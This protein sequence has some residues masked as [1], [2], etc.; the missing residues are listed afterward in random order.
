MPPRW[1]LEATI[2]A[3]T[4]AQARLAGSG[5]QTSAEALEAARL[6][7]V[8]ASGMLDARRKYDAAH[9]THRAIL[10]N[11][12]W[13]SILGPEGVRRTILLR[14]LKPFNDRLSEMCRTASLGTIRVRGDRT[15]EMETARGVLPYPLL[16][17]AESKICD[18]CI[19]V[20]I[21]EN[22]ASE[23]IIIDNYDTLVGE[24]RTALLKLLVNVN[25]PSILGCAFSNEDL[26]PR[27]PE[28]VGRT[29][30]IEEGRAFYKP[31]GGA[32]CNGVFISA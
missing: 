16:S 18:I 10:A 5:D 8:E 29:F 15:V 25:I 26:P 17:G 14:R 21:A 11:E 6:A 24:H 7:H 9:G 31:E 19:Q 28:N 2:K 12:K 20:A 4:A 22:D 3:A 32:K 1:R 23:L 30:W 13:Q 27:L